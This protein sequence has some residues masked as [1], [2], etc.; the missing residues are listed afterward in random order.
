MRFLRT[1]LLFAALPAT[2]TGANEGLAIAVASN[3]QAKATAL[4]AEFTKATKI[5]VRISA[6]STGKLYAQ[7]VN[8][9]PYDI[10]LSADAARPKMLEDNGAAVLGSR[11]TYATGTLTLWSTDRRL[12]N[13]DCLAALRNGSYGRLA[14]ANPDTA[15]YGL[16]AQ[17]FLQSIGIIEAVQSRLVY[18]ENISQT[19]QFVVTGN[20]TFGLI[21][22]SQAQ[23]RLPQTATCSWDVPATTHSPIVQQAVLLTG[24]ANGDAAQRFMRFLKRRSAG[25]AD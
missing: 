14:I 7:I 15:P 1:V 22:A 20:A 9:A 21:A 24:A 10:F 16:A 23:G 19:L 4:A 3:F 11:F 13:K 2:V 6:A 17:E 25:V 18:G 8:G 5:P 12:K